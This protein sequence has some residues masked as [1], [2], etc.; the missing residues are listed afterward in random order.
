MLFNVSACKHPNEL[1]IAMEDLKHESIT[2]VQGMLELLAVKRV[3]K[4]E[5][6]EKAHSWKW[7]HE[8]RF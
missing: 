3:E 8:S 7:T 4:V 6:K 2:I 1:S 5:L